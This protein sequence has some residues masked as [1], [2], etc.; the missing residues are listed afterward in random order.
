MSTI[1]Y[2]NSN[3]SV[4]SAGEITMPSQPAFKIR[5]ASIINDVTGNGTAYTVVF[6][7]ENYDQNSDATSTTF[8]A[9]VT[10][11]YEFKTAIALND[12]DANHTIGLLKIV[13]SNS[14]MT[15]YSNPAALESSNGYVS[16]PASFSTDMDAADTCTV[17]IQIFGGT[18]TI[19]IFTTGAHS[20][21]Y[22]AGELLC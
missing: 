12:V 2:G 7:T 15:L 13:S 18:D 8:T 3:M 5:A 9:P 11:I 20:Y 4:S 21:S 10:G 16:L 19:N 6:S 14:T 17:L 22:F 1:T